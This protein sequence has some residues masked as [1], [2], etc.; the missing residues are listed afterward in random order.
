MARS[1]SRSA[2]RYETLWDEMR[3][4]G[5]VRV[6][7]DGADLLA[8]RAAD[9]R[10]PPQAPR[11]S[12]RRPR[13]RSAPTPARRIADSVE[14]ALSLGKGVMHVAYRRRRRARAASGRSTVHSQHFACDRCGRSF[15]PL[16]PHNFSFNSSLG[17]CPACEG[18]GT[19]TGANPAALLRDPKLTLAEGAV[20]AL[21]R[22]AD[23]QVFA[24]MLAALVRAHRHSDR[25][26]VRPARRQA[27]PADHAR[28]GRAVVRRRASPPAASSASRDAMP[29]S[30]ASSTRGSIRRWKKRRTVARLPQPA[31]TPGRRG[32]VLG[33]RRQPAA[34]RRGG[35][36]AARPDDRRDL[37]P[38]AGP[39]A[40][41]SSRRGS[42]TPPSGRSPASCCA[43]SAT[44]CSS[45]STSGWTT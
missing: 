22:R 45:S 12:G 37:P 16:T 41:A 5:Y 35:R 10:P 18:L 1:R 23:S 2:R 27:P 7:V 34:R 8:R 24:A 44:G 17:W 9:D 33:L 32:G 14:N 15:E 38:A 3:A 11:R 29:P 26:A 40:R 19:Q 36:A 4:S 20:G 42:S 30:S 43:R 28:H 21:A 13:R 39:A 31:G 6:R 25:R